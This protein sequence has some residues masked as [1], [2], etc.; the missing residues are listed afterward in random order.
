MSY[1]HCP[2]C[3]RAYNLATQPTCPHCAAMAAATAPPT[4]TA[5]VEQLANALARATPAERAAAVAGLAH[6]AGHAGDAAPPDDAA[7]SRAL[8]RTRPPVRRASRYRPLLA[9]IA[10]AVVERLAPHAPERLLRAVQA[11]VKALAA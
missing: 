1:L 9:A 6:L 10:S 11:R 7:A 8:Q 3:R 2:T 5:A 4:L